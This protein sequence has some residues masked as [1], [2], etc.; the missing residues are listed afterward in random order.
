M[1]YENNV[2]IVFLSCKK[3]Q[4]LWDNLL[5]NIPNSII[6]YGDPDLQEE[7]VL[8]NQILQLRCEDTYDFLPKKIIL[9]N[10]AICKIEQFQDITHIFKIDDYDTVVPLN[11]QYTLNSMELFDYCGQRLNGHIYPRWHFNKVSKDSFWYNKEYN[12]PEN[13]EKI[14]W[15]D[16]GCG[17][18]L[19]K[20]AM[21][22]VAIENEHT[23]GN[24]H[25]YEDTM[26][27]M[28]LRKK[29]VY[30]KRIPI[31]IQGDKPVN[32]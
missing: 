1:N 25:I 10:R 30:P 22:Y 29:N 16:G 5:K 14:V 31:I 15:F 2:L 17:Y 4:H 19:S 8:K 20:K 12:K 24:N 13:I 3:N 18:I 11:I 7:Y 9:M 32:C 26:V 21:V 6:F 28:I 23:I 27:S